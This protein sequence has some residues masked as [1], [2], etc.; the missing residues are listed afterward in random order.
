L[1]FKIVKA[2]YEK[3]Y[4]YQNIK[5]TITGEVLRIKAADKYTLQ[6][7]VN[8]KLNTWSNQNT[9]LSLKLEKEENIKSTLSNTK[10]ALS[11]IESYRNL[12]SQTL[13]VNDKI[14]WNSLYDKKLFNLKKPLLS[15][16]L[17][18][19]SLNEVLKFLPIIGNSIKKSEEEANTKYKQSIENWHKQEKEFYKEQKVFNNSIEQRKND[20]EL[21][22]SEGITNYFD[23]VLENSKYPESLNLNYEFYFQPESKLL[24]ID[25]DLPNKEDVP[26]IIE[27][28][29]PPSKQEIT[30]K[31]MKTKEFED[32]YNQIIYQITLRTIHEIFESDY[33]K[34][35]EIIV[36]NGWIDGTDSKTGKDFRNCIVSLQTTKKEFEEINLAK[37]KP[38]DCFKHL[39]GVSA[40]S[41]VNLSP[42]RPIMVLNKNDN[43]IIKA[44]NLLENFD[45]SSNLA[46]MRWED[47]E[48]LVRDLFG[49]E[50]SSE[51]CT[52]E[53][54]RA[55]RDAGVDAIA[56]DEGPIKG[57]KFV[58][59]AKR[60]NNLVPVSAVRD[61]YGTVLNEGAVKGILV[62][63]SYFGPDALEFVKNKPLT[64]I[65]GE[66][67]LYL[68]NKH[69]YKM[70]IELQKKQAP[71]SLNS[72]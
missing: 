12:L 38:Q 43:R 27:Y 37:V 52:V 18:N 21:L 62:T 49:K 68:F 2:V 54:T 11:E 44:S 59:Q 46:S 64:L 35:V 10:K 63:T 3:N 4:Y 19:S 45:E 69:G 70:K 34:I 5:N 60:Y 7:K 42:V 26:K 67:L 53:V 23:L 50:F 20:Y 36:L 58:I 9:R 29:Y 40:G 39:K 51:T 48:V 55:S 65:N 30:T 72:Y 31:E 24:I 15:D 57:G 33:C 14:D 71:V 1:G 13:K 25:I 61:L 47:F 8:N 56:F 22:N 6:E 32:F 16:F 41:L 66:Q 28:K 17:K